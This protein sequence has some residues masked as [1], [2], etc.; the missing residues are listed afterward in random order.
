MG[1]D[2]IEKSD[3]CGKSLRSYR[4]R[5]GMYSLGTAQGTSRAATVVRAT[6]FFVT[7]LLFGCGEKEAFDE[8][9]QTL[10]AKDG[11]TRI[12]EIVKLSK[13]QVDRWGM[14]RGENWDGSALGNKLGPDYRYSHSS[15][16]LVRGDPLRGEVEMYRSIE[17]VYR[18][19]DGKLLGESVSYGRRGGDAY[20]ELLLGAHPSAAVCP[21]DDKSLVSRIFIQGE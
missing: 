10:C 8:R 2:R 1:I 11:G 20:I 13:D 16:Y 18:Q 15:Q 3:S 5:N 14:P 12:Y 7:A 9:I 17:R 19:T 4:I 21:V 6:T